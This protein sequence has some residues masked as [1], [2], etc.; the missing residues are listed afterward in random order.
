M[1][2]SIRAHWFWEFMCF[3]RGFGEVRAE[4]GFA[5]DSLGTCV[6]S[7]MSCGI[8]QP[9]PL[10]PPPY[11]GKW[12][13]VVGAGIRVYLGPGHSGGSFS[14]TGG[15]FM[16]LQCQVFLGPDARHLGIPDRPRCVRETRDFGVPETWSYPGSGYTLC[17]APAAETPFG[18]PPVCFAQALRA[19]AP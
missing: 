17:A 18:L 7:Y 14:P 5:V 2:R 8:G 11:T 9:P 4:R 12:I 3:L 13:H 19:A 6:L 1:G 16:R 10:G 15:R